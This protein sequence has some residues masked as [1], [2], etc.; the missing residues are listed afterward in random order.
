EPELVER[1][2]IR[3]V[4]SSGRERRAE[5][6]RRGCPAGI[7]GRAATRCLARGR[8]RQVGALPWGDAVGCRRAALRDGRR[9]HMVVE[10]AVL[11]VGEQ[12]NRVVPAGTVAQCPYDRRHEI[13]AGPHVPRRMLIRL[14]EL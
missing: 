6:G 5:T 3:W 1:R 12:E 7:A 8:V 11:V 10:A 2:A 9:C 14:E 13:L 4:G